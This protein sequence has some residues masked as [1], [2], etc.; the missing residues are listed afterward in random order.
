M[1]KITTLQ[2]IEDGKMNES[3]EY[4][5]DRVQGFSTFVEGAVKSENLQ[6]RSVAVSEYLDRNKEMIQFALK[7]D[8]LINEVVKPLGMLCYFE[9]SDQ[10]NVME[11]LLPIVT[12]TGCFE[13]ISNALN[14]IE[15]MDGAETTS[16]LSLADYIFANG[17]LEGGGIIK[18]LIY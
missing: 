10:N 7:D 18:R 14:S 5:L 12:E 13:K 1:D 3:W 15:N 16:L 4:V 6:D 11:S 9:I 2:P 17:D 8:L